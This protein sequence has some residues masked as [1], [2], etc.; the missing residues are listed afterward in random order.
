MNKIKCTCVVKLVANCRSSRDA[1][2]T[3]A[4]LHPSSK[5]SANSKH[6][7]C[8]VLKNVRESLR[9]YLRAVDE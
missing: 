2:L 8:I 9:A 6:V 4:D 5:N 7:D 1:Q 3:N